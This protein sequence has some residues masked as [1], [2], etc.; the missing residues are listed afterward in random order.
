MIGKS[1][2]IEVNDGGKIGKEEYNDFDEIF[3]KAD[4]LSIKPI[5]NTKHDK[6]A[7]SK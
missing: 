2:T 6:T 5:N 3:L 7:S 4:P 1:H